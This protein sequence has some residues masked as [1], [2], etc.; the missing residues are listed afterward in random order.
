MS[1]TR[2][3][4]AQCLR[5]AQALR[6]VSDSPRLDIELL[7]AAV[8]KKNRTFLFTWP[9]TELTAEQQQQFQQF[10]ARRLTGEP[11]AHIL[12]EREF[13]SLP[14]SVNAT[15]LIPRPDTEILVS[16]ALVRFEDDAPNRVRQVLDL[17]TGTGAIALALASEHPS[18]Q[19]IGVDRMADAVALAEHNARKLNIANAHFFRSDWF[20]AVPTNRFD[21]IVS[22]PPYIDPQDPHL[23]Q[24]D[25]RFEP[26]SALVAERNGLADIETIVQRSP[27]YLCDGGW[28]L[29]EHGYDQSA[30]VRE[31]LSQ[32]G[33]ISVFTEKDYGDNDRVTG[34][35]YP[36]SDASEAQK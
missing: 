26:Y 35:Q 2:I 1:E 16:Q 29:I 36:S 10:F 15:T 34:G 7:L 27:D 12:G 31:L 30:A 24:G 6:P 19:C 13:W 20:A 32:R 3:T 21:C 9:E 5:D 17:G 11:V 28:L 25:V 4:V 22:N 8:L 33:F 23:Q 14:L 18:W